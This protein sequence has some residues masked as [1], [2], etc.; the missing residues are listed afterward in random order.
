M[1]TDRKSKNAAYTGVIAAIASSSCCII[2]LIALIG[3]LG[4]SASSMSWMEPLR[5]YL[6]GIAVVSIG[7][8]WYNHFKPKSGGACCCSVEKTKWYQTKVFLIGITLFC[9]LSICF[10]YYSQFFYPDNK[11]GVLVVDKSNIE[12]IKFNIEGMTCSGCE[13][14]I[15]HAVHELDGIVNVQSSYK[16]GTSEIEYDKSKIS[17]EDIKSA[18]NKTGYKVIK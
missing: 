15:N 1:K 18:I 11:K 5:P 6:I 14:H 12:K 3:G 13:S 4:G 8:A 17:V 7:Y 10:P 16:E 9:A 2:P